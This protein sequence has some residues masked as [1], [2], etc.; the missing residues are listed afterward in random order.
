MAD[1]QRRLDLSDAFK[2]YY[3]NWCVCTLSGV[4]AER[5]KL[6]QRFDDEVIERRR[7]DLADAFQGLA[8]DGDW[9]TEEEFND[10]MSELYDWGDT[11]PDGQFNGKK[12]CW[13]ETGVFN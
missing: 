8:D 10:I 6:L 1:W 5:L 13:I 7:E 11:W 9:A 3:T 2:E 4:I 12:V